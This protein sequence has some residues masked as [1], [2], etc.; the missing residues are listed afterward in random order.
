MLEYERSANLHRFVIASSPPGWARDSTVT[1]VTPMPEVQEKF[2]CGR[3][4]LSCSWKKDVL[5]Q[6]IHQLECQELISGFRL[7]L[8]DDEQFFFPRFHF[9]EKSLGDRGSGLRRGRICFGLEVKRCQGHF[10]VQ[11]Q[12]LQLSDGKQMTKK[13]NVGGWTPYLLRYS[14]VP[15][16]PQK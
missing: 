12:I 16:P 3:W 15:P 14:S 7:S 11:G 13:F 2:N 10:G 6:T 1:A 8:E 9:W 4:H 5:L